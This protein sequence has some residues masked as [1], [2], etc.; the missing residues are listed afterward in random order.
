MKRTARYV[1]ICLLMLAALPVLAARPAQEGIR[2]SITSPE[3]SA[4]VR[5]LVA[6]MG[7]AE[8]TDFQFYKVEWARDV[9]PDDWHLIGSMYLA[10]VAN[11]PLAQWDTTAVPDGVYTLRLRVVRSDGNYS[12]YTVPQ[13]VVANR[14]ATETPTLSPTPE[15]TEGPPP[16]A[17]PTP[18]LAITQPTAALARP[19]PTPTPV[20]PLSP[21]AM[22]DLPLDTWRESLCLG[23]GIMVGIFAVVGVT[24]ALRRLL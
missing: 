16:T 13:V 23:A 22:P 19:S 4:T 18:T 9:Q 8:G 5:G 24:L 2:G 20:R 11:G 15:P 10:A 17:G 21:S 12:D 6:I 3:S 7:T 14:R 1:L